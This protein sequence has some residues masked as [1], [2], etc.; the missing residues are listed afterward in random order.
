MP[1]VSALEIV[2]LCIAILPAFTIAVVTVSAK[3]LAQRTVL[4]PILYVLSAFGIRWLVKSALIVMLSVSA[5]PTVM[6]PPS[7]ML[8][9]TVILPDASKL[10]A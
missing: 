5:S 1:L 6:L 3:I 8:P 7:V 10:V 9:V 4:L 2:L